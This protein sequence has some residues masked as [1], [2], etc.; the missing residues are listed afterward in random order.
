MDPVYVED[1][2]IVGDSLKEEKQQDGQVQKQYCVMIEAPQLTLDTVVDGMVRKGGYGGDVELHRKFAAKICAV[3]RLIAKA[4]RHLHENGVIH[5][6]LCTN[7]CGKFEHAWKLL[8]KLDV[9]PIGAPINPSRFHQSFPPESLQL[10][11][12]D[13]GVYDS[14]TPRFLSALLSQL[15]P[16]IFGPS[17]SLPTKLLLE[18]HWSILI[19]RRKPLKIKKHITARNSVW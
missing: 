3:L 1:V 15:Q 7:T 2:Q 13:G 19:R 11:D 6:N 5:G 18:D 8:G 17:E 9:Q 14:T 16:S 10:N 12:A 4:L